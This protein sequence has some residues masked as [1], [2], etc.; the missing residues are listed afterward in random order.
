MKFF[1]F[2]INTKV[3]E[4]A[5]S[6]A[7]DFIKAYSLETDKPTRKDEKKLAKI[8]TSLSNK[9]HSFKAENKLGIYKKARV[10]NKFMWALREHGIEKEFA[11]DITKKLFLKLNE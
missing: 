11:E 8:N 2:N 4:F 6:L 9:I 3:D 7:D 5:A 1:Q 10:G